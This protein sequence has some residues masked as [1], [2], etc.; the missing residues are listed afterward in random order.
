MKAAAVLPTLLDRLAS[1]GGQAV[2]FSA[3]ELGE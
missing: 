1:S 2:Y 3:Q